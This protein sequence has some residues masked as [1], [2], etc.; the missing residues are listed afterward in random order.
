MGAT[1]LLALIATV[2]MRQTTGGAGGAH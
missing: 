1:L 2:L